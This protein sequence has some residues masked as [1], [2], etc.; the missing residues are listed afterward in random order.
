MLLSHFLLRLVIQ[1]QKL[2]LAATHAACRLSHILVICC[3]HAV[4][5]CSNL[6]CYKFFRHTTGNPFQTL[7][8]QAHTVGL[9]LLDST[10]CMCCYT[11]TSIRQTGMCNP[12]RGQGRRM[13]LGPLHPTH[14]CM[15]SLQ[16]TGENQVVQQIWQKDIKLNL[17]PPRC[18]QDQDL[19][20]LLMLDHL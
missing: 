9:L 1:L 7:V 12:E 18:H 14:Q 2:S 13:N 10:S 8:N 3:L 17:V 4:I 16:A 5:A 19:C 20:C 6:W 15:P 11:G